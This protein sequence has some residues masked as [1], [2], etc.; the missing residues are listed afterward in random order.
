VPNPS[1]H[2]SRAR[3]AVGGEGVAFSSPMC[4]VPSPCAGRDT[5]QPGAEQRERYGLWR[6]SR[7]GRQLQR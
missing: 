1:R 2:E 7:H 3:A 5:Y 6:R 4:P